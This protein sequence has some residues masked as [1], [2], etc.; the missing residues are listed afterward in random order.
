MKIQEWRTQIDEVDRQLVR[1][2]SMRAQIAIEIARA[3]TLQGTSLYD[4]ARE[5]E[6]VSG[7]LRAN[8]GVLTEAALEQLFRAILRESREAAARAVAHVT[9]PADIAANDT[10]LGA[11]GQG[12]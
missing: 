3:K 7:V 4:A 9:A 12:S 6:V 5:T 8:P 10:A 11:R 2:L 1:L